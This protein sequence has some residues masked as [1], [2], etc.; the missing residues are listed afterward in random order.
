MNSQSEA[1]KLEQLKTIQ[2]YSIC[3]HLYRQNIERQTGREIGE[4]AI[5]QDSESD[6]SEDNAEDAQVASAAKI[7]EEEIDSDEGLFGDVEEPKKP[8]QP[9][10]KDEPEEAASPVGAEEAEADISEDSSESEESESESDSQPEPVEPSQPLLKPVFVRREE[11]ETIK[12]KERKEEEERQKEERQKLKAEEKKKETQE[13]LQKVKED[14]EKS[15]D[16]D[17]GEKMPDD[18]DFPEEELQQY[19]QWKTREFA[20][21]ARDRKEK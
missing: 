15:A 3:H 19:E 21:I 2:K 8:V 10:F 14:E 6:S 16:G 11:R 5:I 4:S 12:E 1:E 17:D 20:R 9:I 7:D 13:L 18:T